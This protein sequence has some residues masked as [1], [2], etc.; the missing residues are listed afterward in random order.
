[1]AEVDVLI[2]KRD[3]LSEDLDRL[4]SVILDLE[5]MKGSTEWFLVEALEKLFKEDARYFCPKC[6]KP[7]TVGTTEYYDDIYPRIRCTK[8]SWEAPGP[9]YL[10]EIDAALDW[11]NKHKEKTDD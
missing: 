8:C 5:N 6:K 9:G 3:R 7:V 10:Y 2:R 11:Y 1:M 4:N